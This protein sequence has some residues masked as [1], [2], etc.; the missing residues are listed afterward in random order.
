MA[1]IPPPARFICVELFGTGDPFFGGA[2][3]DLTLCESGRFARTHAGS[4]ERCAFFT[5]RDE[6]L[7]A[8][9]A[10]P[11]RR[12]G[13]LI[14]AWTRPIDRIRVTGLDPAPVTITWGEFAS[15]NADM[16]AFG[17][18]SLDDVAP[19]LARGES[20]TVGGGAAPTVTIERAA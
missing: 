19:A 14:S 20:I 9:R 7:A 10:A 5:T 6:A 18:P 15:A 1:Q 11:N 12:E 2:A 8:G 16:E 4:S 3:D 17:G 13:A